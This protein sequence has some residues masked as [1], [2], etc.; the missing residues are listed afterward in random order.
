MQTPGGGAAASMRAAR[1]LSLSCNGLDGGHW[2][3]KE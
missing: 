2:D 1:A 3:S